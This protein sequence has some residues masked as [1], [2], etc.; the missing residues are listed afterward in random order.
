[1]IETKKLTKV[2]KSSKGTVALGG[3]SFILNE[4]GLIFING[5]SGCGKTTLLNILGGLDSLTDGDMLIDGISVKS[6]SSA[7]YDTYRNS[8]IGFVF[9]EYNL[10]EEM[11]VAENITFAL[12][13]Q[14]KKAT[15]EHIDEVLKSVGLAGYGNRKPSEL[16]GGQRQRVA[17]ARAI[18]KSADII[19]ADEPTGALDTENSRQIFEI[20]KALSKERLV[21]IASHDREA[22][23]QYA[24]RIITLSDGVI[25]NDSGENAEKSDVAERKNRKRN[26]LPARIVFRLALNSVK[27][28]KLRLTAVIALSIF[29]LTLVGVSGTFASYSRSKALLLALYESHDNYISIKKE[30]F[31]EYAD[32]SG[33]YSDGYMITTDELDALGTKTGRLVK[34]IYKPPFVE[35]SLNENYVSSIVTAKN[36]NTF[37]PAFSGFMELSDGEPEQLGLELIAGRLPDGSKFEI[38]ISKYAAESF[39]DAGYRSY[40]GPQVVVAVND[41]KSTATKPV[42]R[43]TY[44][45]D[46]WVSDT[47]LGAYVE[48]NFGKG[49]N[50]ADDIQINAPEEMIGKTLFLGERNYTITGII[51]TGFNSEFYSGTIDRSSIELSET[52]NL[53]QLIKSGAFERERDYGVE[54]LAFVGKGRIE[55]ISSRYPSV[56]S[57]GDGKLNIENQYGVAFS[58]NSIARVGDVDMR[59][60][61]LIKDSGVFRLFADEYEPITTLTDSEIITFDKAV[62]LIQLE[63]LNPSIPNE[64]LLTKLKLILT[65]SDGRTSYYNAGQSIV[66]YAFSGTG[67]NGYFYPVGDMVI[68]SDAVFYSLSDGREG[69]YSHAAVSLPNDNNGIRHLINEITGFSENTRFSIMNAATFQMD[70]LEDTIGSIARMSGIIG[71]GLALFAAALLFNFISVSIT[72]KKH[73]IGIMRAMGASGTDIIRIFLYESLFVAAVNAL[74]AC[75]L[76]SALSTIGNAVLTKNFGIL[77]PIMDFELL[78]FC[79]IASFALLISFVSSVIPI[80]TISRHKPID[81]IRQ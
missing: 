80:A 39:I 75:A 4:R 63:T 5:K 51:D 31:H 41:E 1:M 32:V 61:G 50:N 22:A 7:E 6:F 36:Y 21:I 66:G 12:E 74:L 25:V 10:I 69:L 18:V 53:Q 49:V 13:L 73:Q 70:T 37:M 76:T 20:L 28:K 60:I 43:N 52:L 45:W 48:I 27:N 42:K 33:W 44:S 54:T 59:K 16:S 57:L 55:E 46:E 29:S 19:I 62:N 56:V 67:S 24:D 35:L 64:N 79:I 81:I 15:A 47:R 2:Y 68:V 34:G 9:Q 30:V 72:Q 8:R 58:S 17:I 65:Y 23:E 14:N 77:F 3:V 78:Q 40:T 26:R 38:A 11:T 71:I